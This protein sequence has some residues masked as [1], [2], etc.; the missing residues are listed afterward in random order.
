MLPSHPLHHL[1]QPPLGISFLISDGTNRFTNLAKI[2]QMQM[3]PK[4]VYSSIAT[5]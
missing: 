5:K 4:N 1:Q 2:S 3:P